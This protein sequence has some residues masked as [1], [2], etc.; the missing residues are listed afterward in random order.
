MHTRLNSLL[1]RGVL[2]PV[3]Y[4]RASCMLLLITY[5]NA[6]V[7]LRQ[8]FHGT[9]SNRN[10]DIPGADRPRVSTGLLGTVPFGTAIRFQLGMLST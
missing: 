8:H 9:D 10:R 6:R 4:L 5:M 1:A 3:I 7:S 2:I